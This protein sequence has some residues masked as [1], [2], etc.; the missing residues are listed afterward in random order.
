VRSSVPDVPGVQ[1]LRHVSALAMIW[2]ESDKLL[3]VAVICIRV[4]LF[5]A[6]G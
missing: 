4:P 5:A 3:L 6:H 2:V 1:I